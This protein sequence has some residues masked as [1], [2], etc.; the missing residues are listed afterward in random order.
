M[1]AFTVSLQSFPASPAT[2]KAKGCKRQMESA[3]VKSQM[4]QIVMKKRRYRCNEG[5]WG[6]MRFFFCLVMIL[7]EIAVISAHTVWTFISSQIVTHWY[8]CTV[9][10]CLSY[11]V[12][13]CLICNLCNIG[14]EISL[15]YCWFLVSHTFMSTETYLSRVIHHW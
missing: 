3:R 2:T 5:C 6:V 12:L 10:T 15:V 13:F 11:F 14:A 7:V 9:Y 4:M 1:S 8:D